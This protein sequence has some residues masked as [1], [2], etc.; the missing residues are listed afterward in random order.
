MIPGLLRE[1]S[2]GRRTA[3][4]L[5]YLLAGLSAAA[6][7]VIVHRRT[8]SADG[9][10][11]RR[12]RVPASNVAPITQSAAIMSEVEVAAKPSDSEARSYRMGKSGG[13]GGRGTGFQ[14][15][16]DENTG[17]MP[18][19]H[20]D[21]IDEALSGAPADADGAGPQYAALPPAFGPA[22]APA[23]AR[24]YRT[25]KSSAG[26]PPAVVDMAGESPALPFNATDLTP[27]LL[28]YR[29]ATADTT[30][31]GRSGGAAVPAGM[32]PEFFAPRGT[33]I[34]VCLL[35]TVDT[36]NPSAVIQLAAA[37]SLCFDHRCQLPFGTR[38]LGRVSG[39]PMRDRINL[40][41]DTVLYPDGLEL[42]IS[43]SAVEADEAG[44]S[45]RPGLAAV[46]FPPPLWV[47]VA[48]YFSDFFAGAMGLLESRAQQ[49]YT[50]GVGGVSLQSTGNGDL[51]APLYQASGQAIQD[52]T[53]ARLKEVERRYA[54]FYV[55][56]A[57]TACW[58]QLDADLDLAMA[59]AGRRVIHLH[60]K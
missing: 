4:Y 34:Y 6:A 46:Y 31:D 21:P 12:A 35:T 9:A 3:G 52:F 47:Q 7:L 45:I 13:G 2:D 38:F 19:P 43:A 57:G 49:S 14:P 50:V 30:R 42:P 48:P 10:P 25:G 18:V 56:P 60:E 55:V 28:G 51:R 41:V 33:L 29:D 22:P 17:R 1:K 27:A 23:E 24:S 53:Q 39:A 15:G 5:V 44:R 36:S 54:S 26:V 20:F 16:S 37:R 8:V 59:H 40:A 32:S 11:A 58:L